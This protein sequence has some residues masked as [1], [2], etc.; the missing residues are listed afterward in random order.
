MI[1]RTN[2]RDSSELSVS[3][4]FLE[5][6]EKKTEALLRDAEKRAKANNRRTLLA[7]DL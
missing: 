7:R 1:V 6:L 3:E 5:D 4:E 2:I